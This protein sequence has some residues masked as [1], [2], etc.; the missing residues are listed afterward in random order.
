MSSD[1]PVMPDTIDWT[2][3]KLT[4]LVIGVIDL[5]PFYLEGILHWFPDMFYH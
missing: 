1:F 3:E 4:D 2:L 5:P